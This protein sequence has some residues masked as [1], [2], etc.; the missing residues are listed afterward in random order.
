MRPVLKA[1]SYM[2]LRHGPW[3]RSYKTI[4]M[5]RT[6]DSSCVKNISWK[7]HPTKKQIYGDLP[8]ITT[9]VAC[10]RAI[11]AGHCYRAK[12]QVISDILLWIPG[13]IHIQTQSPGTQDLRLKNWEQQWPTRPDGKTWQPR[14]WWG[15]WWWVKGCFLPHYLCHMAFKWLFIA[16]LNVKS[17][18]R[19]HFFHN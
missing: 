6:Q 8:P 18:Q 14:W 13:L 15:W 1:S 4:W 16:C 3:R 19:F 17:V 9:T 7:T 2:V 11:F 10:Q 5:A 12:D